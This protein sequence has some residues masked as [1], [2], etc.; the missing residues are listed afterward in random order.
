[1]NVDSLMMF[2][3]WVGIASTDCGCMVR[4]RTLRSSMHKMSTP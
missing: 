2:M 4:P 3:T 1:M